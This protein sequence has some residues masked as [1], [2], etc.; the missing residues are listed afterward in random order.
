MAAY[1]TPDVD[2][3]YLALLTSCKLIL[4]GGGHI[5]DGRTNFDASPHLSLSILIEHPSILY[6]RDCMLPS[7][8]S[9][10]L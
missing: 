8:K 2:M 4:F 7:I 3:G 9:C 6:G 10:S 5:F 1:P